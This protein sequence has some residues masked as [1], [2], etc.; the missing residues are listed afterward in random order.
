MSDKDIK[1]FK[2]SKRTVDAYEHLVKGA[3]RSAVEELRYVI[4]AIIMTEFDLNDR[5][6][7]D[8]INRHLEGW[9]Q[10]QIDKLKNDIL[11]ILKS[12]DDFYILFGIDEGESVLEDEGY[13]SSLEYEL[14]RLYTNEDGDSK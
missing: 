6:I 8:P 10:E 3:L 1:D 12:T 9:D 11:K 4:E 5:P 14:N 2:F 7:Y 13:L